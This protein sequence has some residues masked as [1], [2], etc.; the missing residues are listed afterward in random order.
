MKFIAVQVLN[1]VDRTFD[2]GYVSTEGVRAI[3]AA[4][5]EPG[6]TSICW[7]NNTR[8]IVKGVPDDIAKLEAT[9]EF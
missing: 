2:E 1:E 4:P 3:L 7:E 9:R 8:V 5:S 6:C